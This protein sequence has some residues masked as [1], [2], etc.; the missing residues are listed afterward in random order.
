VSRRPEK[1]TDGS[2]LRIIVGLDGSPDSEAALDAVALRAWPAGSQ[3][4]VVSVLDTV[5]SISHNSDDEEDRRWVKES[6]ET[7]AEK[8]RKAGL[9]AT[10][11][12]KRGN[13]KQELIEETESWEADAIFVGAKGM[14]GIERLLLGSVSAAV[15]ARAQCSVEVRR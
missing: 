2:T 11:L 3:V 1:K 7:S 10:V 8:F 14:R 13:P 5:M 4:R 15:A 12:I 9:N 6:F